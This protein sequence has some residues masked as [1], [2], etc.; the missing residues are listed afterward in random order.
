LAN[1]R[2][3]AKRDAAIARAGRRT[4]LLIAAAGLLAIFAPAITSALGL[5]M[6]YEM[7]LYLVSL[8]A[9]IWALYQTWRI[10]QKGRDPKG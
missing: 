2:P 10:W 4:A 1:D 7:L 6:R 9:F 3:P 8:A 5:S